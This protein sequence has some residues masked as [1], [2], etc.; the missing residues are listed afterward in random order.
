MANDLVVIR[1]IK[2][3]ISSDEVKKRMNDILGKKAGQFSASIVSA[4]SANSGLQK[5]NSGSIMAAAF[6]AAA[7]DLP[8]DQNLG[9]AA[10]VPYGGKAQFQIMYKGFVQ[11]A[12][13]TGQYRGM[14]AAE[15]YEDELE[16]YNPIT[17]EVLFVK[18]IKETT[19]RNAAKTDK[20]IGYYA[21]FELLNGFRQSKYMTVN[22][23]DN[24]AK[25]YSKSYQYDIQGHKKTSRWS[26][27]F[28]VMALKTVI[29]L[30]LSKWGILSVDMQK[31]LSGDQKT[32]EA[33]GN[34]CYEDNPK[35][36]APEKAAN[37]FIVEAT[38]QQ[39][40][41][42]EAGEIH[43]GELIIKAWKEAKVANKNMTDLTDDECSNILTM[44]NLLVD[45]L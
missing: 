16:E 44:I 28:P 17:K 7:L 27:D 34:S 18:N 40:L 42:I 21:W 23:V 10:I 19:Q 4:V 31:A 33:E 35:D 2:A 5:C 8:I 43:G 45:K 14:N 12:I 32:F 29:K 20:I 25:A 1:E 41:V 11:L 37:P 24:H 13:R 15:V 36:V 26:S 30:L 38:E 6:V 39:K 3:L 22:E 9:F